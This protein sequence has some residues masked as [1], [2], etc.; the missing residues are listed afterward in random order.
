ML[1]FI[2][3]I[4]FNLFI[5]E[6]EKDRGSFFF[7]THFPKG[8]GLYGSGWKS[9]THPGSLVGW[10]QPSDGPSS[11]RSALAGGGSVELELRTWT[12]EADVQPLGERPCAG[13]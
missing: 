1:G 13:R 8:A 12:A 11:L 3:N 2:F 7:L 4:F 9:G 10:Q 5:A 6:T